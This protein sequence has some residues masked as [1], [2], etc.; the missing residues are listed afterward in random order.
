MWFGYLYHITPAPPG[1]VEKEKI[2]LRMG[3]EWDI[4]KL[5]ILS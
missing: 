1:K 3:M 5:Y 4:I 2:C